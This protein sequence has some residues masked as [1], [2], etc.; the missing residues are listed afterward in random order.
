M[1]TCERASVASGLLALMAGRNFFLHHETVVHHKFCMP[2]SECVSM[3][4]RATVALLSFHLD[5]H[6]RSMRTDQH[7][8]LH[9]VCCYAPAHAFRLSMKICMQDVKLKSK[10]SLPDA[11]VKPVDTIGMLL[12]HLFYSFLATSL[13][14]ICL[15]GHKCLPALLHLQSA[16][17][18]NASRICENPQPKQNG[19]KTSGFGIKHVVSL[20]YSRRDNAVPLR[21]YTE[22]G[23]LCWSMCPL[24]AV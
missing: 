18:C 22:A 19:H 14:G 15:N 11:A 20:H 5:S 24:R 6:S 10:G 17:L 23:V 1:L 9:L 16:D 7:G 12:T 4:A 8:A 3:H 2:R 13:C 21:F